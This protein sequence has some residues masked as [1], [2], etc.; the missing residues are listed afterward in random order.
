MVYGLQRSFRIL[1]VVAALLKGTLA[2]GTSNN[3]S[4]SNAVCDQCKDDTDYSASYTN[5]AW[6]TAGYGTSLPHS[7]HQILR[8][9][10][11]AGKLAIDCKQLAQL[12]V[13]SKN[14]QEF[15]EACPKTCGQCAQTCYSRFALG[16]GF[17]F[18][19]RG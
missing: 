15:I 5:L 6:S 2:Y 19:P 12:G 9:L 4:S 14:V 18:S 13:P 16:L 7:C 11:V 3:S 1:M 10:S 8:H 17:S